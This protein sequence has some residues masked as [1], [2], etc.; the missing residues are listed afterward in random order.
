MFTAVIYTL[1]Y[2]SYHL[3]LLTGDV[4]CLLRSADHIKLA[5]HEIGCNNFVK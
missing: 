5:W 4:K 3:K 2:V 1:L